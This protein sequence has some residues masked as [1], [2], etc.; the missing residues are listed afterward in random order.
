MY[1]IEDTI[2]LFLMYADSISSNLL[3]SC[4]CLFWLVARPDVEKHRT[5]TVKCQLDS[6]GDTILP[7]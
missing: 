5:S 4:V 2:L 3:R 6:F 1:Y 7:S